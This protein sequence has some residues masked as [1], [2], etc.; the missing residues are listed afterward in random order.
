[1]R[2]IYLIR[3]KSSKVGGAEIYLLRLANALNK[4]GIDY[5][6]I[7]SI[8]P[9]F[10]PSWLRIILFNL[11]VCFTKKDR[12]YFSLERIACPDIYRAGDGVHKVFLSIEKK[13]KFNLLHPVYRFL[14]EQCFRRAKHI[15]ANSNMVKQEIIRSYGINPN[16]ID[17]IYNGFDQGNYDYGRSF[18]RLS[19]EFNLDKEVS[20]LLYVGSGFKRKGVEEFLYIV[21]KLKKSNIKAFVIGKE[22]NIDHYKQLSGDLQITDKVVFTGPRKDVKDFYVISDVFLLPAHYEPFGNVVLEAMSLNNAVFTTKK[23]G[24]SELLND[25]DV[26]QN[27]RDLSVIKRINSL[28]DNTHVLEQV[29]QDNRSR[30][31]NY[32]ITKNLDQ[33]V[34]LIIRAQKSL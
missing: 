1:M 31:S 10:L 11:Q 23:C 18:E 32:T 29:K 3:E 27:P 16:K 8:F 15:V 26:M 30:A 7:N 25:Q 6:I 13:S 28:L 24:A 4:K 33:T 2:K 34:K 22:K 20:I 17:V 9:K 5:Q 19:K 21:S 12:F 14:E